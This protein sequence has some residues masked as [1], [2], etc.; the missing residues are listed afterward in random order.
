MEGDPFKEHHNP[1]EPVIQHDR[2]TGETYVI[3]AGGH[4]VYLEG[5]DDAGN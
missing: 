2:E 5:D 1:D 3:N 4:K